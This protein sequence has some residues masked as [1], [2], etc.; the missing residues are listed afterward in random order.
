MTDLIKSIMTF[1]CIV[2]IAVIVDYFFK[3]EYKKLIGK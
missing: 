2:T 1:S 3:Y